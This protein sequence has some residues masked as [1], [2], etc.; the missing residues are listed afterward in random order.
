MLPDRLSAD[1][2]SLHEG[3]DR[4][5]LAVRMVLDAHG[6]KIAHRFV[7]GMMRSRASLTYAQ[8]QAARST[9]ADDDPTAPLMAA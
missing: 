3:V 7:R 8:A 6:H 9:G 4:P 5:V 2:C 1:L